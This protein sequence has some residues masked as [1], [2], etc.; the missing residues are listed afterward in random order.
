M[1]NSNLIP[2]LKLHYTP[3]QHAQI[4][5][6]KKRHHLFRHFCLIKYCINFH[7]AKLA[8]LTCVFYWQNRT[9]FVDESCI[10]IVILQFFGVGQIH[11]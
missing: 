3:E 2:K 6:I 1:Q 5:Q 10:Y 11:R 4:V 7:S 9:G 8:F